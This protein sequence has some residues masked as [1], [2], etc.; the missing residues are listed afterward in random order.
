MEA[1][2][3]WSIGK[4]R[5]VEGGFPGHARIAQEIADGPSRKRVGIKP[6]GRQP[7]REGTIIQDATGREIGRITS[8]G[9]GPSVNGPVAMGYVEKAFAK[10]GTP[11]G[12]LVRDKRLEATVADTTF[13]PHRYKK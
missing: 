11:I 5:R 9:F 10:A 7:A 6:D 3:T 12:L 13:F 4:R 1:A 2:L 8:G